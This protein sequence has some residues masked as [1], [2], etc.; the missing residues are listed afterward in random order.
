MNSK[1]VALCSTIYIYSNGVYRNVVKQPS[2]ALLFHFYFGW[3]AIVYPSRT[4]IVDEREFI[5]QFKKEGNR[6]NGR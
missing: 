2:R 6:I 4:E 5:K 3:L 1:P